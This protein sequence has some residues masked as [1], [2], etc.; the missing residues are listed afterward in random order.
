[1]TDDAPVTGHL[2]ELHVRRVGTRIVVA[3]VGPDGRGAMVTIGPRE[4]AI[5]SRYLAEL[6]RSATA[7][8]FQRAK[9]EGSPP[10]D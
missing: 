6:S 8:A 4:A 7:L 3:A 5:V 9:E 2:G 10:Y 1:M